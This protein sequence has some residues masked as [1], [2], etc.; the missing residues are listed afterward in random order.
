MNGIVHYR[1]NCCQYCVTYKTLSVDKL[2][3]INSL[4]LCC[5]VLHVLRNATKLHFCVWLPEL[6]NELHPAVYL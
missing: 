3:F 2:L 6:V 5:S 4:L 1:K